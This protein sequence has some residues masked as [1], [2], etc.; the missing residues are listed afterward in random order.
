MKYWIAD[1]VPA[2]P[3]VFVGVESDFPREGDS[4]EEVERRFRDDGSHFGPFGEAMAE[5]AEFDGGDASARGEEDA[6]L[7]W[8]GL[9][10]HVV[11]VSFPV[12]HWNFG[13]RYRSRDSAREP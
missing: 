12:L 1:L 2:R 7:P 10:F 9:H 11:S 4:V 6:W 13:N 3:L 8:C 5:V